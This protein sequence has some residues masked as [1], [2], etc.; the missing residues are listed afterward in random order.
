MES[1]FKKKKW[2][3]ERYYNLV[4]NCPVALCKGFDFHNWPF[5]KYLNYTDWCLHRL[6]FKYARAL[7]WK[8]KMKEP[9]DCLKLWLAIQHRHTSTL[10]RVCSL[11]NALILSVFL[12]YRIT[13]RV[14]LQLSLLHKE[15][16][17]SSKF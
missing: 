7:K 17:L 16:E 4:L 10:H 11:S 6:K 5:D 12:K 13:Q 1:S 14:F 3:G 8:K 15:W 2:L 9:S